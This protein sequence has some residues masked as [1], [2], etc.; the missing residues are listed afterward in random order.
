MKDVAVAGGG[1]VATEARGVTTYG[2]LRLVAIQEGNPLGKWQ[3][4]W[5]S[6]KECGVSG[7]GTRKLH[8]PEPPKTQDER[9]NLTQSFYTPRESRGGAG[10]LYDWVRVVGP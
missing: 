2:S 10:G 9:A 6:H 1:S 4:S 7:L 8:T 5:E 3:F